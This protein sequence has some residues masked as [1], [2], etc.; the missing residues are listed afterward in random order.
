MTDE[1]QQPA[2]ETQPE[3]PP[4]MPNIIPPPPK[5]SNK[6]LWI[7]ICAAVGIFGLCSILCIAAIAVVFIEANKIA[8]AKAPIEAVLDSYMKSMAAKD[9][10]SAYSLFSPRAQ[11]QTPISNVQ[12]LLVGNFYFLFEGYQSLSVQNLNLGSYLNANPNSPQGTV[13]NVS[14]TIQY[15]GGFQGS[16]NG[17]LEQV[18][19]KWKI[20]GIEVTVP[21]NKIQ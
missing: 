16:F 7:I 12:G 10:E 14:G 13:A 2:F 11:Q 5:K 8:S 19:G 20:F 1:L 17:T 21:P 15:E 9:A 3:N 18:D 6:N 4:G